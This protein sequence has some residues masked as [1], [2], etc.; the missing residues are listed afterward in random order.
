LKIDSRNPITRYKI[1]RISLTNLGIPNEA[2]TQLYR[3]LFVHTVGFYNLV[4]DVTDKSDIF[5]I[6]V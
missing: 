5:K 3:G 6:G 1:D 4:R 2:V